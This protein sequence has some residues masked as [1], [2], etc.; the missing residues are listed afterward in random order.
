M[1][2]LDA[3]GVP[4]RDKTVSDPR[5]SRGRRAG[6]ADGEA[7]VCSGGGTSRIPCAVAKRRAGFALLRSGTATRQPYQCAYQCNGN[8]A[9]EPVSSDGSELRASCEL[10][11]PFRSFTMKELILATMTLTAC[12]MN[13]TGNVGAPNLGDTS[14]PAQRGSPTQELIDACGQGSGTLA[15]KMISR[16]PYLQQVTTTS[17][18]VGWTST[19]PDGEYLDVTQPDGTAVASIPA[20]LEGDHQLW[21]RIAGLLP[22]TIYCY[23]VGDG[24][25][26][27]S[28]TGFRTAPTADTTEPV[29]FLAFGDS[30]GGGS[31]QYALLEQM[32]L[33]PYRL[34]IHTGDIAYDDGTLGQF[35]S[36]VFHVYADLFR[37]IPFFPAAGNHE[38]N[39]SS[40]AAPFRSVFALPDMGGEKWYSFDWGPIH[41]AALDTEA[42][43]TTQMTWLDQDLAATTLPWK[44]VYM[45]RPPY[46]SGEH[47]SDTG[48]RAK[49]APVVEQHH[50]QLV[51]SGHDHDYERMQLQNGVQYLVTGG[52]GKGTRNVGTSSFTEIS[53]EVIHFVYV[54]VAGDAMTLHAIDATGTEFDS[55]V[56]AR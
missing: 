7:R 17:A 20:T 18:I 42:D 48:L 31:D 15:G 14:N 25:T 30:G 21:A 46:S 6:Q 35:E 36:N 11:P 3:G 38:Y 49:L 1:T 32:A 43:Y 40:S 12:A 28:R 50:V 10:D 53:V 54:E 41:F 24:E 19:S 2:G 39:S 52:G 34:M 27:V 4:L 56:L 45:H 51:L 9:A 33:F 13:E 47:G 55:V 8:H 16:Q 44:V 23:E 37:S 29:R 22:D 26:L 5:G